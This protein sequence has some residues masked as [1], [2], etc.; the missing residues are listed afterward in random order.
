MGYHEN[1]AG[2]PEY[3]QTGL[4]EMGNAIVP[5]KASPGEADQY[6]GGRPGPG[7]GQSHTA[8]Y[9]FSKLDRGATALTWGSLHLTLTRRSA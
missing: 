7:H 4:P 2:G 6:A 8:A 3:W 5:V 1:V 9:P